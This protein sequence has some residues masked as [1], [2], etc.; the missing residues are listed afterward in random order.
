MLLFLVAASSRCVSKVL[1]CRA[2]SS[3]VEKIL[4]D[5]NA[6]ETRGNRGN[7]ILNLK[8]QISNLNSFLRASVVSFWFYGL[9]TFCRNVGSGSA[10]NL[11]FAGMVMYRS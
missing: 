1:A 10:P 5:S 2:K 9:A 8:F 4:V 3:R 7:K 6:E 11:P